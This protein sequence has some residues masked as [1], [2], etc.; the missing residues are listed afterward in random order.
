[1]ADILKIKDGVLEKCTNRNITRVE[2]PAGVKVICKD[3]FNYCE[4]LLSVVISSSVKLIGG[5]AFCGCKSLS[6]VVI[7]SSV[8]TIGGYA[9]YGCKSLS[10]MVV[11][12]SVKVIGRYAFKNCNINKFSHPCLTI[13]NGVAIKDNKVLYCASQ[14]GSITISAGVTSICEE[15]FINCESLESVEIPSSVTE[16]GTQAFGYCESLSSVK[17]GGT[18]AQW[19]AVEGKSELLAYIPASSVKCADGEWQ[20][21]VVHVENGVAVKC[22]EK[23]ATSVTIPEGVTEIGAEAFINCESLE[24]VEIPSSVTKIGCYAFDGC[25]S[26]ESVAFGG[27]VTQWEAVE[28]ED[29]WRRDVPASSVKCSDGKCF[30]ENDEY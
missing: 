11:P 15:A 18:V 3:A 23:N 4:S 22:L 7:P 1:M 13:K 5:G 19:E 27:T 30:E 16:I 12:S 9:F 14:S 28:K 20:K 21:P 29:E 10:S 8:T 17:F 26:L 2:I 24:L 6:S 25:E